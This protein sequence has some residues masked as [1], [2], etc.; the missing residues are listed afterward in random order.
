MTNS[1]QEPHP[2][3]FVALYTR[4]LKMLGSDRKLGWTLAGANV[5]LAMAM[6]GEPILFGLVIDTLS[7]ASLNDPA[8]IWPSLWP[9]FWFIHN[10]LWRGD[11][12]LG[13]SPVASTQAHR[14]A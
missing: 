13:R 2:I 8:G 5:V 7:R 12:T 9:W 14:V 4:V 6:F 3:S 11:R 10:F 1:G